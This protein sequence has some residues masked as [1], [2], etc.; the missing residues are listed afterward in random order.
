VVGCGKDP[1]S[2]AVESANFF[3]YA[4][5]YQ[6]NLMLFRGCT[7]IHMLF[8]TYFLGALVSKEKLLIFPQLIGF[9]C[10]LF[11]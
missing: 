1:T 4:K 11:P 7:A 8:M 9:I 6:Y 3:M 2:L 5:Q 10:I